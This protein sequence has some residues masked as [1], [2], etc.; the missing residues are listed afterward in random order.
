MEFKAMANFA[1]FQKAIAHVPTDA[2][3]QFAI[4]LSRIARA[5]RDAA[6]DAFDKNYIMRN[7]YMAG[8]IISTTAKPGNLT[9]H[10]GTINH[11]MGL[12]LF[13][14]TKTGNIALS[15]IRGDDK[16]GKVAKK[17]RWQLLLQQAQKPGV[18]HRFFIRESKGRKYIMAKTGAPQ[19]RQ[20]QRAG[21][22]GK[23]YP[24]TP[25]APLWLLWDSK[26]IQIKADW[27]LQSVVERVMEEKAAQ[28]LTDLIEDAWNHAVEKGR[29]PF[30]F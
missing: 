7:K 29:V 22:S 3:R 17:D 15:G 5:G 10:V 30:M 12:H 16:R 28:I 8:S 6:R 27:K 1:E 21:Y 23:V 26:P 20:R 14:G 19:P 24:R 4:G 2:E 18:S 13:G 11:L 25:I 9:A